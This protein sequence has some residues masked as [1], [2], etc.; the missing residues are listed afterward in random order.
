MK[1]SRENELRN[2]VEAV[3]SEVLQSRQGSSSI[4]SQNEYL[5]NPQAP[6]FEDR[7]ASTSHSL[8]SLEKIPGEDVLLGARTDGRM[9]VARRFFCLFVLFDLL[10]TSLTW[11]ICIM[12]S[13]HFLI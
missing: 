4:I 9:S 2:A 13:L 1:G 3:L 7:L 8:S 11:L 5:C 10:L 6:H 12:V